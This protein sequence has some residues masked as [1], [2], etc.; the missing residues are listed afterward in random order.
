MNQAELDQSIAVLNAHKD[1][2]AALPIRRKIDYL[3]QVRY[4][5]T[6]IG[7][8]WIAAA[9]KA[10]QIDPDSPVI[11]E[12]WIGGPWAVLH[13]LNGMEKTLMALAEG[14]TR[15]PKRIRC[16]PDG[17]VIVDV[18][19]NS[20]YDRLLLNG[21]RAE[22]WMQPGVTPA[23]LPD[24]M[25]AYYK[26][27]PPTGKVAL[28]LGAGNVAS[29]APL[30][31][32]YKLYAEGQVC[33]LKMNP[34]NDYLGP[35]FEELFGVF[36]MAGYLR[37]AYGGADM[38][39]YLTA[40]PDIDEIH[41]TGSFHTH[42]AIV[43]GSGSDGAERKRLNQPRLTKRVTSELGNVSP[44][45][46]V[47]GPWTAADIRFQAEHIV[48]QKLNNSGF[49]CIAAQVLALPKDW[50]QT[51]ALLDAIR[52]VIRAL[53]PRFAYYPGVAQRQAAAVAHHPNA[54]LLDPADAGKVPRTLITA[55]DPNS[56]DEF[57]FREETF[58]TLIAET[59]LPGK[60]A[61]EFLQNA[62]RFCNDRLFGTLGASLIIHPATMRELGPRFEDCLADLRYGA[63]GVNAWSAAAYLLS[64]VPWGAYPGHPLND[65]Q[66]GIGVVHNTLLF[67]KS[68][69]SVIYQPFFPF[70]RAW[71]HGE[72]HLSPKPAWFVTNRQARSLGRRLAAYEAN[73]G[74]SHFPRI[75]ALALRG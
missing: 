64:P 7:E 70:P 69:K 5:I 35:I 49:N 4:Q 57:C 42:D 27:A 54:E 29:I 1:E 62:V 47:P 40:H 12:E 74:L 11:G 50:S 48:T 75:V 32:L 45:I 67:G 21:Y 28:V 19:P 61:A 73:P 65:I 68:Q 10:K 2:W 15:V 6:E 14:H 41:M 20:L 33:L 17:Q 22:V 58:S 24:T 71:R 39:E 46:V 37:F 56:A 44:T 52:A 59:A 43:F 16:R 18:F 51:P 25:A 66:S 31:V 34:V 13:W 55:L 3:M 23:T 60:T 72:F 26:Q 36:V 30:D 8:R 53:P 63:I 9:A 38:G